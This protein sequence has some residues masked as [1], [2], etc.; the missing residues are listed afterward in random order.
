MTRFYYQKIIW[1]FFIK[2]IDLLFEYIDVEKTLQNYEVKLANK[3]CNDH[4][5]KN[6]D[7]RKLIEK[8]IEIE[9]TG[10]KRILCFMDD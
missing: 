4:S 10:K 6:I 1:V 3:I 7:P 8:F 9:P 2:Y 5:A